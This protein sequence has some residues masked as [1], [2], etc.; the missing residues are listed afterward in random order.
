VLIDRDLTPDVGEIV[1]GAGSLEDG[2]K[3]DMLERLPVLESPEDDDVLEALPFATDE[4]KDSNEMAEM[5]EL[6]PEDEPS[7]V[8]LHLM[9][10]QFPLLSPYVYSEQGFVLVILTLLTYAVK[11]ALVRSVYPPAQLAVAGW[12]SASPASHNPR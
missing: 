5:L 12:T 4:D 10:C 1:D 11:G 2:G 3:D 8:F 7:V 6:E 9:L